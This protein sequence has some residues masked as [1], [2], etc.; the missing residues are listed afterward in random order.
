MRTSIKKVLSIFI[1]AVMIMSLLPVISFAAD[2]DTPYT[3]F[4]YTVSG[5]TVTLTKYKGTATAV[6]VAGSY[7]INGVTCTTYLDSKTVF[8]GNTKIKS[9]TLKSGV[10]FKDNIMSDL[11][12]NC[13]ALTT[14][15]LSAISTTNITKMTNMFRECK[16]LTAFNGSNFDT[17]KVTSF[18]FMFQNASKA[19]Y[20]GYEN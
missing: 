15:N 10:K 9:V 19:V 6:V 8:T 12:W 2:G 14:V 11:F 4:T 18:S 3:D 5:S 1:V 17:S 7:V 13:T 20:S 16:S